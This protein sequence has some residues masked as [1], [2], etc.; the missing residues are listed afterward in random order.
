MVNQTYPN[1]GLVDNA[2]DLMQ[3]KKVAVTKVSTAS[4]QQVS[5]QGHVESNRQDRIKIS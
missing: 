4:G 5:V 2:A 3:T 1:A